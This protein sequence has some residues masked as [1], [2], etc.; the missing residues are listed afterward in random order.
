[1]IIC[2]VIAFATIPNMLCR[3]A[4]IAFFAIVIFIAMTFRLF[5]FFAHR[6]DCHGMKSLPTPFRATQILFKTHAS[7]PPLF[8]RQSAEPTAGGIIPPR[9]Q[10]LTIMAFVAINIILCCVSYETFDGNL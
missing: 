7:L 2:Y 1:M 10:S 6:H 8:S 5:N 3:Y 4:L 9:F